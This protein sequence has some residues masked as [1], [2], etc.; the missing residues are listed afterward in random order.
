MQNPLEWTAG[1][2]WTLFPGLSLEGGLGAGILP[3]YGSPDV[4][5]YVG[6]R[7]AF[8]DR[9]PDGD[10]V[11]DSVDACPADAE[12]KDGFQDADGCPDG[13]N[14][15]DGIGDGADKCRNVAGPRAYGG[16]PPPDAD[17]DGLPDDK[18]A[19]PNAVGKAE[20]DGCP[21]SDGDGVIDLKDRCPGMPGV[22]ERDGCPAPPDLDGDGVEDN[23]DLCF[24]RPGE[25]KWQGCPDTDNDGVP[26]NVDNCPAEQETM[27]GVSDDDGCPDE[28]KLVL[29]E[30]RIE[31]L[32]PVLFDNGKATIK[33]QSTALLYQ[34]AALLQSRPELHLS[35]EGH[36][37]S[38]GNPT[39]NLDLSEARAGAVVGAVVDA[40]VSRGIA[41]D[42]L[43]SVGFGDARPI[44]ANN[45]Q[46]GKA[47]NRRVELLIVPAPATAP[48]PAPVPAGEVK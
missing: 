17:S 28:G 32:E 48:A 6:V 14:D 15:D 47:Q 22:A 34:I 40:L 7:Y 46:R 27:N 1:A 19:C 41:L 4:R 10:G 31:T 29:K 25:V 26:D 8:E 9:D 38:T 16:C 30:D 45:T 5:V 24:D 36:T 39:K 21:D 3:G 33:K 18:D 2:R 42:R 37:D 12:D 43:R 13:D 44:A 11:K 20:N 35:I 23:A